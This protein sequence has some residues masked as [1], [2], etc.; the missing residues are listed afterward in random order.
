[1]RKTFTLLLS[2]FMTGLLTSAADTPAKLPKTKARLAVSV[3]GMREFTAARRQMQLAGMPT[4]SNAPK[5][6][7]SDKPVGTLNAPAFGYITGPDGTQ[8]YYTQ[9]FETKTEGY[10]TYLL[11]SVIKLYDSNNQPAGTINATVP[12]GLNVNDIQ[13]YGTVTQKLFDKDESTDE[14]LVQMHIPGNADNNYEGSYKTFVYQTTDNLLREYDGTGVL[15]DAS[16]GWNAYQRLLLIRNKTDEASKDFTSIDVIAPAGWGDDGPKV[17]HT[18]TIADSLVNYSD[19][20]I[21]NCYDI[22]GKPYYVLSNYEKTW[23]DGMGPDG[24]YPAQ[25][26]SNN[27]II[28][29]FDKNYSMVDSIAVPVEKPADVTYRFAT[30]GFMSENDFSDGY[31]TEKGKHAFIVTYYDLTTKSDEYIYTFDLFDAEGKKMKTICDNALSQQWFYLSPVKGLSDQMAFLQQS[32][33]SQQIKILDMPSCEPVITIPP[34]IG[35]DAIS[36]TFDRYPKGD[37]YQYVMNISQADYDDEGNVIARINWY[38]PDLTLDHTAKFNLGQ[39]GEY[40]TPLINSQTLNP[41]V[42][43]T[44]DELE[45][46]Y[47]AKKRRDGSNAIDNVLEVANEDGSVI[48]SFRG[49]DNYVLRTPALLA[50]TPDRNQLQIAY[51]S[52]NAND[53]KIDFYELPFS[54]F[55]K[56]GDGTAANPYLISTVGD[57]LQIKNDPSASYQLANNI[58]LSSANA[59]WSPIADFSGTL[60]GAGFSISNLSVETTESDAGLF[61][62]ANDKSQIKNLTFVN[63]SIKATGDNS[64]AG[65]VAGESIGSKISNVHVVDGKITADDADAS[66]ATGG[67]I[68]YAALYTDA[69]GCSFSGE[70]NVPGARNVGGIFGNARTSSNVKA[71]YAEGSFTAKK[72]LGGITGSSDT[73]CN[74]TDSHADV[75]LTAENGIGGIVGDNSGRGLVS[76]CRAEGSITATA[77]PMWGGLA[78]GGIAGTLASDWSESDAA[79]ISSNVADIDITRPADAEDDGT[80]HRIAGYTIANEDT[81]GEEVTYKEKGLADNYAASTMQIDGKAVASDD[82]TSVEGAS[83][84]AADMGKDFFAGLGFV[85]G[86]DTV[87]PWKGETGMPVLYFE[88]EAKAILLAD[89]SLQTEVDGAVETT[90]TVYGAAAD[91]ISCASSDESI[92]KAEITNTE[93]SK[94]TLRITGVK[95]GSTVITISIGDI[96][97]ECNVT[98]TNGSASVSPVTG[99]SLAVRLSGG[100]ITAAGAARMDVYNINGTLTTRTYGDSVSAASLSGGVYVVVATAAD[101]SRATAKVV[102]R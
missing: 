10:S 18:F 13:V 57:L 33:D 97:A 70:I 81:D 85:Y 63:P 75:T 31:F 48:K 86:N 69:A 50:M 87:A 2:M 74:I 22:D 67:L 56:G 9:D 94:A 37:S 59:D 4:N 66:P 55:T 28:K 23:D 49:D 27:Y 100:T 102:I 58:D 29:A 1:M 44:D 39:D 64:Y 101:G 24:W 76:R 7:S 83:K 93:G 30:F 61:G 52:N 40:F 77:V 41:Y 14:V 26:E 72:S 95:E 54:K 91:E 98:V 84:D 51:Y 88:N 71:C 78:L 19:G 34:S 92:A 42:F 90:A 53:Y 16:K 3:P 38:N 35:G 73:G 21:I 36:T 5:P 46:I 8:W 12:E 79:V 20:A 47:I 68:G 65:V 6:V 17:E 60:D 45:Y 32:G 80:V 96:K 99:S 82:A 89:N 25:R 62:L 11:K 43:D 15:F